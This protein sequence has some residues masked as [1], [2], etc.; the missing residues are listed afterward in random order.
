MTMKM[1]AGAIV[2]AC[3]LGVAVEPRLGATRLAPTLKPTATIDFGTTVSVKG[4]GFKPN[5]AVTVTLVAD[6]KLT[7]R[8][9]ASATGKFVVSFGNLTLNS[10]NA[11]TLKVVGTRGSR[12]SDVHPQAPC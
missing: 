9:H 8:A 6:Q 2:A 10:C 7:R 5:E 12:F 1:L 11:Y 4:K 3:V